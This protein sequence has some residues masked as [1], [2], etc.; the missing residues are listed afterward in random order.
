[1]N[2]G[3]IMKSTKGLVDDK[4]VSEKKKKPVSNSKR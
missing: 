4:E 3:D 2:K 1:M